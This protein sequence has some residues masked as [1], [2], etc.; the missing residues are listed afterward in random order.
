MNLTQ[1]FVKALQKIFLS[2]KAPRFGL[3]W[4]DEIAFFANKCPIDL[5][6]KLQLFYKDETR[7]TPYWDRSVQFMQQTWAYRRNFFESLASE[8]AQ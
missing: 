6:P 7:F 8:E 5:V 4:E 2:P 3:Y 1:T